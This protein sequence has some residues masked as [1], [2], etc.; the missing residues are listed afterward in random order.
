MNNSIGDQVAKLEGEEYVLRQIKAMV[1]EG[2][3][4]D[5]AIQSMETE[6]SMKREM[7]SMQLSSY[8]E[9]LKWRKDNPE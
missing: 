1:R 7:L 4:A 5:E 6:L 8:V 9:F 2:A 3:S